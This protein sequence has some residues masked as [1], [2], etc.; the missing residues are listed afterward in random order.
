MKKLLV[1]LSVLAIF[2]FSGCGKTESTLNE[3]G[4]VDYTTFLSGL[5][6]NKSSDEE[7]YFSIRDLDNNGI[8]ELVIARNGANITEYTYNDKIGRAHV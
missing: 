1:Y 7:L 5:Y 8:P 4:K 2:L 6:D 3:K